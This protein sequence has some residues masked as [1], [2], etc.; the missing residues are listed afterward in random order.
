MKKQ[1]KTVFDMIRDCNFKMSLEEF[2][3]F[4]K[5]EANEENQTDKTKMTE[6]EKKIRGMVTIIL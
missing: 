3:F 5:S 2:I 4:Q 1:Y 6:N